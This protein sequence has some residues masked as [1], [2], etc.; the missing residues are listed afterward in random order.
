MNDHNN[1][2]LIWDKQPFSENLEHIRVLVADI[3]ACKD[4]GYYR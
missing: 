3:C 1:K 4:K 2:P